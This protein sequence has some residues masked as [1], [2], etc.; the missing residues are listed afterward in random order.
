MTYTHEPRQSFRLP[1]SG[2]RIRRLAPFAGPALAFAR[3]NPFILIGAAVVGVAGMA[4]WRN[5]DRIAARAEPLLEDARQRGH[6]LVEDARAKGEALIEQ[7]KGAGEAVA[8]RTKRR[9]PAANGPTVSTDI[10]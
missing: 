4:A 7:A 9:T 8:A 2:D 10:N 3:R 5:R 6:A 1:L